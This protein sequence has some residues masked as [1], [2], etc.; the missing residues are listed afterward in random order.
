MHIWVYSTYIYIEREEDKKRESKRNRFV[1]IESQ[2]YKIY[3]YF[4]TLATPFSKKFE[5]TISKMSK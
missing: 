2:S 4:E 3:L 1:K 5:K